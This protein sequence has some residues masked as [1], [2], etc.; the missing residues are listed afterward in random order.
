M[1]AS[2]HLQIQNIGVPITGPGRK[3]PK[4]AENWGSD[5][6]PRPRSTRR[7][8]RPAASLLLAGCV[9]FSGNLQQIFCNFPQIS[10]KCSNLGITLCKLLNFCEMP[11]KF[12]WNSVNIS[13]ICCLLWKSAKI[14]SL[15][16]CKKWCEGLKNHRNLEWCKGKNVELEKC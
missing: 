10:L 12:C 1:L 11:A 6:R 5:N 16:F 2:R 3:W 4:I 15:I 8:W 13:K 9:R 7:C 14:K